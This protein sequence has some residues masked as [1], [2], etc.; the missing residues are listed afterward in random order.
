MT[1]NTITLT[2][3]NPRFKFLDKEV[4]DQIKEAV[5]GKTQLCTV[6]VNGLR[7]PS[8]IVKRAYF[9]LNQPAYEQNWEPQQ[10]PE[11]IQPKRIDTNTTEK[12]T[13]FWAHRNNDPT[14][15]FKTYH[16]AMALDKYTAMNHE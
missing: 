9:D 10:A 16:G 12:Q 14:R 3:A 5:K 2:T 6:F 8:I 7:V 1:E 13:F 4:F 11:L 15:E